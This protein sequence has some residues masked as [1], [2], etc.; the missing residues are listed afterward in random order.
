MD[1]L[2]TYHQIIQNVLRTYAVER[3]KQTPETVAQHAGRVEP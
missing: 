3:S 1:T 2:D